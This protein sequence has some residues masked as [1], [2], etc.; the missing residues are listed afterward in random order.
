[1]CSSRRA[2]VL[3]DW[4]HLDV[5]ATPEALFA[6]PGLDMVVIA[7][8]NRTHAP[9]AIAALRAGLHVVVDKPFTLNV[10]QARAAA[11]VA[12]AHDRVLVRF[13]EPAVGQ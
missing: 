9:L 4:P 12:K 3:A 1:M 10:A 7:T 5:V 8:P 6:R 13:P 2:D 11:T